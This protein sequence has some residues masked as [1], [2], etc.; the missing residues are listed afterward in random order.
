[1]TREELAELNPDAVVLDPP[2]VFDPCLIGSVQIAGTVHALYEFDRCVAALMNHGDLSRDDALD[3]MYKN[4]MGT[5]VHG[6]TVTFPPA[7]ATLSVE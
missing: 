4:V 1:V 2:H 7:F 6:E 5:F 3:H